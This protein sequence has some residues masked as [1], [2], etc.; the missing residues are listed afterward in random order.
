MLKLNYKTAMSAPLVTL[1]EEQ[2]AIK[3][4]QE[5]Q[6][7][8]ALETLVRSHARIAYAMAFKYTNNPDHMEDLAAEGIIGIMKAADKF[9]LEQGTR[10]A[11]YSRWWIMTF[12]SQSLAK[13]STVIDMPSRTYIDAK[14]GRLK[15]HPDADRAHMAV[16]GGVDLDAPISDEGSFSA[17]DLLECPRPNPEEYAEI[18][19]EEAYQTNILQD[20]L[21]TLNP[22][23]KEVVIRR[24]L[25][26]PAD[27]LEIIAEDLD[28]TRER[29]RQIEVKALTKLK[30]VLI[31]MGF[32]TKALK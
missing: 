4:W 12:I 20:A 25:K 11:T 29:V 28:V 22:R 2:N 14:M 30:K 32:S 17:L 7:Q 16:F 6:D 26:T 15:E 27:T 10:F 5:H 13:V 1:E 21:N 24:K 18:Q 31:T 23:E 8:K 19:S 3:A 9:D